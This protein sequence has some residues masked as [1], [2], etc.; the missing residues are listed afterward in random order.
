MMSLTKNV[1]PKTKIFVFIADYK[2]CWI[3]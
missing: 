2:I 3:F 1:K